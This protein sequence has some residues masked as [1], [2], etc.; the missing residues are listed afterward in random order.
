MEIYK[1]VEHFSMYIVNGVGMQEIITYSY[2]FEGPPPWSSG[3]S[4][5]LQTQRT[6]SIPD[7]TR[8]SEK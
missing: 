3:Q 5:W 1:R 2:I 8:F 4:S 6:G 7:V